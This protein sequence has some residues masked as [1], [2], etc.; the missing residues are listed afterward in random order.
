M[1]LDDENGLANE[2]EADY[3]E[4]LL[5]EQKKE[6]KGISLGTVQLPLIK[7]KMILEMKKDKGDLESGAEKDREGA[8]GEE[9]KSEELKGKE[10]EAEM[11]IPM[12][13]ESEKWKEDILNVEE[14][15]RRTSQLQKKGSHSLI[16]EPNLND[17]IELELQIVNENEERPSAIT[18]TKYLRDLADRETIFNKE[19]LN[20]EENKGPINYH[21]ML[22]E[23]KYCLKTS[24]EQR[25]E[26]MDAIMKAKSKGLTLEALRKTFRKTD[27]SEML[28][29]GGDKKAEHRD[30]EE[31]DESFEGGAD[32]GPSSQSFGSSMM[33]I[34]KSNGLGGNQKKTKGGFDSQT[35]MIEERRK[36]LTLEE[37]VALEGDEYESDEGSL[38][39]MMKEAENG[40]KAIDLSETE[41]DAKEIEEV[42]GEALDDLQKD[43]KQISRLAHW[44]CL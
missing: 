23:G 9:K 37:I 39:G 41:E 12:R 21:E 24:Q 36:R 28:K 42:I 17:E 5:C 8:P 2:F 30:F 32:D 43:S 27:F 16:L 1:K 7:E 15:L 31:D 38:F 4:E 35:A 33:I 44:C 18:N 3:G 25:R 34:E 11:N 40:L 19:N 10:T 13:K 22:E 6:R 14:L 20:K 26:L 29:N